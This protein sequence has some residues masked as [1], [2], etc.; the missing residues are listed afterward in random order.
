[1]KPLKQLYLA[2][3]PDP[4]P[5]CK[6][7]HS[8]TVPEKIPGGRSSGMSFADFDQISLLKGLKVELEHTDD[9]IIALEI[10]ADH[11]A[12]DPK[13]YEKLALIDPEH[14]E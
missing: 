2:L 11:L 4:E 9:V 6:K 7:K 14:E 5:P 10:S 8:M 12:E 13:Y 1:M 3:S